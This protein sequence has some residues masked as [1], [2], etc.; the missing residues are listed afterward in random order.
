MEYLLTMSLILVLTLIIKTNISD[1]KNGFK[2]IIKKR[3]SK[4]KCTCDL[5][6]DYCTRKYIR[7]GV[8]VRIEDN[9]NC[10]LVRNMLK[11]FKYDSKK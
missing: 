9:I 8:E 10:G 1:T 11:N 6:L 7:H 2:R 4:T 5:K 3:K